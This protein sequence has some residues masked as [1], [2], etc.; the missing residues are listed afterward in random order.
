MHRSIQSRIKYN[1]S[2]QR[3]QIYKL[4]LKILEAVIAAIVDVSNSTVNALQVDFIVLLAAVTATR[5]KIT[6]KMSN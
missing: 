6:F 3:L 5:A 4:L 2:I 1:Q